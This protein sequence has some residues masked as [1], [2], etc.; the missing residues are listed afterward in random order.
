MQH[1]DPHP[2]S[3]VTRALPEIASTFKIAHHRETLADYLS[4]SPVYPPSL[5]LDLTGACTRRCRLCPSTG[6]LASYALDLDFVDR[7]LGLL[8]GHTHGL[9]LSGG[10]P[11]MATTFGQTVRLARER[12]FS[13]VGVVT[14]GSLLERPSVMEALLRH[15]STVRVSLYDWT[16]ASSEGARSAL[17]SV[18]RLRRQIERERSALQIG[19]SALTTEQNATG[20]ER[21]AAEAEAAGAHWIYFHPTC[22]NWDVGAPSRVSQNGVMDAIEALRPGYKDGFRALTYADRYVDR[23]V[24]FRGYHAAHFLL[25]IGANGVNYLGAEVKY[26]QRYAIS[27]PGARWRPA[28]LWEEGRLS[29]IQATESAGYP[30]IGSRHRGVLY[31]GLVQ[32]LIDGRT[33]FDELAWAAEPNAFLYPHL[34]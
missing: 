10:E 19:V 9:L 20:L 7:L 15:V 29:R 28:F 16:A 25:V 22:V 1:T 12:G 13:D 26:Q 24:E 30:P 17:Q 34:L 6:S 5:E 32:G 23:S 21:L 31:S 8:E 11:T 33:R 14:N 4:G 3:E 27:D 2:I 18:E